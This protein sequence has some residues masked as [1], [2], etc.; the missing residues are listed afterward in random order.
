MEIT[1]LNAGYLGQARELL[2]YL[3]S[4]RGRPAGTELIVDALWPDLPPAT[5]PAVRERVMMPRDAVPSRRHRM[6]ASGR[7][8]VP[9]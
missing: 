4:R 3:V 9:S 1:G 2:A 5:A 6:P 8:G 7:T